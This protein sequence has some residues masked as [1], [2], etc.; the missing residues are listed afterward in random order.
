[1]YDAMKGYYAKGV[2][3]VTETQFCLKSTKTEKIIIFFYSYAKN[4]V[5]RDLL[6]RFHGSLIEHLAKEKMNEVNNAAQNQHFFFHNDLPHNP[7]LN[8]QQGALVSCPSGQ[9]EQTVN[10]SVNAYVG[11]NPTLTTSFFL[12]RDTQVPRRSTDSG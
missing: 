3:T 9:W 1:M 5:R 12:E 7:L 2:T 10:L 8:N 6:T 4:I 11:S